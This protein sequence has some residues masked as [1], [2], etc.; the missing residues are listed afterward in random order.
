[1]PMQKVVDRAVACR[2][3]DGFLVGSLEIMVFV[4]HRLN[5]RAREG[6][7]RLCPDV[8]LSWATWWR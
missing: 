2:M 8:V 3:T 6:Y 7:Y 1:M 5:A 4:S